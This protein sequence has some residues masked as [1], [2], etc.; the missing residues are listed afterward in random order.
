MG[1]GAN[2]I[3]DDTQPDLQDEDTVEGV[4]I[5]GHIFMSLVWPREHEDLLA[6]LGDHVR[7]T[8]Q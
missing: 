2:Q 5:L 3:Q 1:K 8:G 4:S 6:K 7:P